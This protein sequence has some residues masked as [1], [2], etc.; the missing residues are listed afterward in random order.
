MSNCL[1]VGYEFSLGDIHYKNKRK[2]NNLI[3]WFIIYLKPFKIKN[4]TLLQIFQYIMS[5]NSEYNFDLGNFGIWLVHNCSID[6]PELFKNEFNITRKL[7]SQFKM[8]IGYKL[9]NSIPYLNLKQKI[10]Q[11]NKYLIKNFKHIAETDFFKRLEFGIYSYQLLT[12]SQ[13]EIIRHLDYE[14]HLISYSQTINPN[15]LYIYYSID[16]KPPNA[17]YI[18]LFNTKSGQAPKNVKYI[19]FNYDE[20]N[21]VFLRNIDV[22]NYYKI[23]DIQCTYKTLIN[24][25]I[26]RRYLKEYN[27]ENDLKKMKC[28][29]I[30]RTKIKKIISR[31]LDKCN[32]NL[33]I[34]TCNYPYFY[35]V[36]TTDG[37]INVIEKLSNPLNFNRSD[38]KF[39]YNTG[40]IN[41]VIK[42]KKNPEMKLNCSQ[43]CLIDDG[44]TIDHFWMIYKTKIKNTIYLFHTFADWLF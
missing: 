41:D 19:D 9:N 44:L 38:L 21:Y 16:N 1:F 20:K 23:V 13:I 15:Q 6:N 14:H 26:L 4:A 12:S 42:V 39:E 40:S 29:F 32:V 30:H 5:V 35:K 2:I 22:S 28:M 36:R 25:C 37:F 33:N 10:I 18:Q 24:S 34:S 8:I 3:D 31:L 7:F 11:F 17:K 43:N 27:S